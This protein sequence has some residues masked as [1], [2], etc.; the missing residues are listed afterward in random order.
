[1]QV[2]QQHAQP[3]QLF[4]NCGAV[5]GTRS[6]AGSSSPQTVSHNRQTVAPT[7]GYLS[8]VERTLTFGLGKAVRVD[9]LVIHWTDGTMQDVAVGEVDH[10]IHIRKPENRL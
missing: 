6:E 8:Q 7:R 1:V 2:S 10:A 9:K 5:I 4:W 3:M